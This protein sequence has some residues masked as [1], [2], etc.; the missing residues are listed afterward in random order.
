MDS[1]E[2]A[3][4]RT[5]TPAAG[6][7]YAW[8]FAGMEKDRVLP[9]AS[10]AVDTA[11]H[12]CYP[13]P[14]HFSKP[15]GSSVAAATGRHTIPLFVSVS[16]D[17]NTVAAV[18]V[19][20]RL[21]AWTGGGGSS[22]PS[23]PMPHDA[24]GAPVKLAAAGNG[25]VV[26]VTSSPAPPSSATGVRGGGVGGGGDAVFVLGNAPSGHSASAATAARGSTN[27]AHPSL[28]SLGVYPQGVRQVAAAH[29]SLLFLLHDGSVWSWAESIL[30][31]GT[32]RVTAVPPAATTYGV[33]PAAVDPV[34]LESP[35]EVEFIAVGARQ[36][37]AITTAGD[38]FTW[39]DGL[40]GNTG[41]GARIA[42]LHPTT[43]PR[44]ITPAEG[45][46]NLA[47][48]PRP[49][50][51]ACT[52]GQDGCKR[53]DPVKAFHPDWFD[54]ATG[55]ATVPTAKI[56]A[57]QE[58]PRCHVVCADG[59]LWIAGTTHKG[60]AAD[61]LNKVMQPEADCLQ[62]YR[63]GGRAVDAGVSNPVWTGAAED[64]R[65]SDSH[66]G[67]ASP[68]ASA[69]ALS[70]GLTNDVIARRLG[71]TSVDQFGRGGSTGYL[72]STRVVASIPGHIHSVALSDDGRLFGWGCGSD[73][74][75]GLKAFMRGP[76]GSK[77]TM[78]CYVSTPSL[79][80]ALEHRRVLDVALGR[81]ATFAIVA[82]A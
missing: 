24:A 72:S 33:S 34:R 20:G 67:D 56:A 52:R 61:H 64:L 55:T 41:L 43:V 58:G 60:L 76:G 68:S 23:Y 30:V 16:A 65:P 11:G 13:A 31:S 8:G 38:L 2:A 78:K 5:A 26:Y 6:H 18:D 45:G 54:A 50:Y 27:A 44:L 51:V 3:K 69:E 77:R 47:P 19:D 21:W 57:G 32:G 46:P 22:L 35:T 48:P 17:V 62:F 4:A 36:A 49:V 15:A 66:R 28:L 79:V 70:H 53:I 37:A 80:E 71:M 75:L 63:V 12:C 14:L 82:A 59:S 74:R 10:A 29:R 81:Y 9:V 7:L 42:C 39:G 25:F 40:S 73:G 1:S